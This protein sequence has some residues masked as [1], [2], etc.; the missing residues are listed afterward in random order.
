MNLNHS[1]HRN[2][3][4]HFRCHNLHFRPVRYHLVLKTVLHKLLLTGFVAA[5]QT[6]V[7][8]FHGSKR[9]LFQRFAT[10]TRSFGGASRL[11][12]RSQC[13]AVIQNQVHLNSLTQKLEHACV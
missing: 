11:N 1:C 13:D 7:L 10:N 8:A 4:H 6:R 3:C 5:N 9:M 12:L 2:H